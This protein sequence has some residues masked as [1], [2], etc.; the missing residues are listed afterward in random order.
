VDSLRQLFAQLNHPIALC[1]I[2][3]M[4]VYLAIAILSWKLS[5]KTHAAVY[6]IAAV[7]A[8]TIA[9]CIWLS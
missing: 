9:A 7:L 2:G 5:S 4:G 6:I 8:G 3:M 1:Y